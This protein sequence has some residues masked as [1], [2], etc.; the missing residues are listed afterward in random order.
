MSSIKPEI[1]IAAALGKVCTALSTRAGY[2][3]W[4]NAVG[5]VSER[6]GGEAQLKFV[7]DGTSMNMA[8]RIDALQPNEAVGPVSRTTCPARLVR[9]STG[10]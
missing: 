5:E 3:G 8:F 6:V 1:R 2:R 9:S 10:S 7:K 4:W